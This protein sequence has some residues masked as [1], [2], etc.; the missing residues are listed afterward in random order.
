MENKKIILHYYKKN[1]KT[2]IVNKLSTVV[3]KYHR[4]SLLGTDEFDQPIRYL[5]QL[6]DIT[7]VLLSLILSI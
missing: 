2:I 5:S 4:L 1:R 3:D 7:S 6:H